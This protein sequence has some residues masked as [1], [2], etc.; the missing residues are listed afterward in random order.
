[1]NRT[2][3]ILSA[4][5]LTV[6]LGATLPACMVT[7]RGNARYGG[8]AVVAYDAPPEPRVE[9]PGQ[10]MAGHVWVRGKWT[11]QNGQWA[12]V[13]GHWER[14]RAGYAWQ[15]GRWEPHNGSWHWVEGTWTVSSNGGGGTIVNGGGAVIVD[16]HDHGDRPREQDH[17]YDQGNQGGGV[18]VGGGGGGG[19]IV[20][21]GQGGLA[22]QNGAGTVLVGGGNVTIVGPT[23]APPPIRVENPGPARRGYV[24]LEGNW[25]WSDNQRGYEWVP[26]H[27]ERAKANQRWEPVRWELRGNVYVKIGG[28]WG[29]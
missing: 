13:D 3:R 6:A 25:M 18:I 22:A 8:G 9:N 12:W 14:D 24:W 27:W 2:R 7:A 26:G 29:N 1:M 11:W 20:N 19:V 10:G 21:N 5:G 15:D 17:R 16:G 4:I 23:Q 28:R